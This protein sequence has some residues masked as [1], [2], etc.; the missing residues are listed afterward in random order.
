MEFDETYSL[1]W[2]LFEDKEGNELE[3]Y[4]IAKNVTYAIEY[5]K[6]N[7]FW[8]TPLVYLDEN[9]IKST[10]YVAAYNDSRSFIVKD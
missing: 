5:L 10:L 8:G 7:V 4:V 3:Y 2:I 6:Q 9:Y 1:Y